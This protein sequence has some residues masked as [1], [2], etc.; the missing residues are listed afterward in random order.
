MFENL[1][2]KFSD[3]FGNTIKNPVKNQYRKEIAF[4]TEPILKSKLENMLSSFTNCN[5]KIL[6]I[7]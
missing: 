3:I 2:E 4:I 5:Y 6:Q 7:L 1:Q